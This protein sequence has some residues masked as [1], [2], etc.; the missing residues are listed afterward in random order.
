M[1][2]T[3]GKHKSPYFTVKTGATQT[4]A[5]ESLF[6]SQNRLTTNTTYFTMKI[7]STQAQAQEYL[8]HSENGLNTNA[9]TRVLISQ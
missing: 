9:S 8:F 3:Q 6:H 5:Q 4:E 1:G 7:G 2:S